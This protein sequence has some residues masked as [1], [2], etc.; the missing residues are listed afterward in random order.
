M[1]AIT[2]GHVYGVSVKVQPF[3]STKS[4]Q[5]A[6]VMYYIACVKSAIDVICLHAFVNENPLILTV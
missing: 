6:F 4:L 1:L 5:S 3:N 2:C